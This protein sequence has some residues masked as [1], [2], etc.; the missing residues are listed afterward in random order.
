MNKQPSTVRTYLLR[1]AFLLSLAFVIV[2]PVA[3]GQRGSD[4]VSSAASMSQLSPLSSLAGGAQ[5]VRIPPVSASQ[6]MASDQVGRLGGGGGCT[7][8]T[9]VTM[10]PYPL[11]VY[12][13]ANATD[14]TFAYVFG[15]NTINGAQHAEANQYDPVA[16]SWSPLASMTAGPDYLFHGEYGGNG[17]IYVM[18]GLNNGTLNRIYTI[19]TNTWS[20]GA[21]VPVAVYDHGHA[22]SNGKIYVIGGI[23]GGGAS[24]TVF[25]Y[26][27]AADTWSPLAP[28]PQAEFNMAAGVIG[29]KIYVAGGSTGSDWITNLYIYDIS[30]NSWSAGVPMGTAANY[31]AGTVVGDKLWVIGGG[32]PFATPTSLNNTQIYD[33]AS[34]TWSN[35]PV[36]NQARSFADAVT[37]NGAGTQSA[38]IVGGFD[39]TSGT[40]LNSVEMNTSICGGPCE[41]QVLIVYADTGLPTQLQSEILA[42]PNVTAV[43]LFDGMVGTPDLG[44]LQQYNIVVPFTNFP[45]ADADTMGNNLADY[46]DG[47]GIV[48][49]YRL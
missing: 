25:A 18:G 29:G 20:T 36:L 1:G 10:A 32:D 49:R 26:D 46:V 44:L 34:N 21:A 31:P 13:A 2:M 27:V 30:G 22:Y 11:F 23:V 14:G 42:E 6:A 5:A 19:A 28:L 4:K 39:S 12:G 47:G 37:L 17:N 15:G 33:P 9:W 7:P 35:G 3:L 8:G 24:N 16:N 43:D 38:L 41:F 48:V 45:F 40:S